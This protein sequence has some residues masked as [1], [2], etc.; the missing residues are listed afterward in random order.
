MWRVYRRRFLTNIARSASENRFVKNRIRHYWG[1]LTIIKQ[2]SEEHDLF[3]D[4]LSCLVRFRPKALTSWLLKLLNNFD[5]LQENDGLSG[6]TD[7]VK[8]NIK[9]ENVPYSLKWSCIKIKYYA[10]NIC[11][12][13]IISSPTWQL[14]HE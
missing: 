7:E 10:K 8:R 2:L 14:C 5:T 6:T 4:G 9:R 3:P 13:Y 11:E 12:K 1:N